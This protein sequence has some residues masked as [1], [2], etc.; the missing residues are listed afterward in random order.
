MVIPVDHDYALTACWRTGSR[1]TGAV[2][3][4][5]EMCGLFAVTESYAMDEPFER[6][7]V[8]LSIR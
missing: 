6:A 5:P 8:S 4:F 7:V 1:S 2:A 3:D